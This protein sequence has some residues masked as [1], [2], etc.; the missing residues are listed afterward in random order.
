MN[1]L[2]NY[3][4]GNIELRIA[5]FLGRLSARLFMKPSA[6]LSRRSTTLTYVT[7]Y[8]SQLTRRFQKYFKHNKTKMKPSAPPSRRS[9]TLTFLMLAPVFL[10]FFDAFSFSDCLLP[11]SFLISYA[12]HSRTILDGTGARGG[13]RHHELQ[14]GVDDQVQG[15]HRRLCHQAR[16]R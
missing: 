4:A 9:T 1:C 14:D 2:P 7:N 6:P 13:G 12:P 11:K 10:A 16:V 15:R 8:D 3:K 5:I